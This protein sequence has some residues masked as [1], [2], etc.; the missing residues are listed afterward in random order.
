[1]DKNPPANVGDISLT[2]GPGRFHMQWSSWTGAP[3][4]LGLHFRAFELQELSLRAAEACMPRAHAPQ[5]KL[6]QWEA[7]I[8]QWRVALTHW[9]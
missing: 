8:L 7:H 9:N 2:S 1:M 4:L 6:L 3:Q 5:E